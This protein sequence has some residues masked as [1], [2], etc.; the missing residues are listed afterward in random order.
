[1]KCRAMTG[2]ARGAVPPEVATGRSYVAGKGRALALSLAILAGG[3]FIPALQAYAAANCRSDAVP[4]TDWQECSKKMLLLGNANLE[5]ANLFGTDF[6]QTDLRNAV[7]TKANLEKASFVRAS[8]A[9]ATADHANFTKI[10]AYRSDFSGISAKGAIFVAAEMQR[11]NFTRSILGGATFEKAEL[12]RAN[13]GVAILTDVNFS[14][15]NLSR[16][17]FRGAM[18]DGSVD[19]GRAFMFLTRIEG[20]NLSKV[21]GLSQEQVELACGDEKTVLPAGL[22]R[23]S[24]WPCAAPD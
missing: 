21:S 1:M 15:A 7:L 23:P 20:V 11:T 16:A 5:G 2:Y 18:L 12:G 8:I 3:V 22:S 14:V 10:E 24:S 4:G 19:F 6:T 13:F 17:N 9:G